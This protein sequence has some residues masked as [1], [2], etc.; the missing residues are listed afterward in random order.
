MATRE[1]AGVSKATLAGINRMKNPTMGQWTAFVHR[2]GGEGN[3]VV[4][5]EVG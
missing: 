4:T 3:T 1:W 2:L 5:H